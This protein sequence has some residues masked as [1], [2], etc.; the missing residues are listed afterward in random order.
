MNKTQKQRFQELHPNRK[1]VFVKP[2]NRKGVGSYSVYQ[3]NSLI[4]PTYQQIK[5]L[6][7]TEQQKWQVAMQDEISSLK[8]K[9][10]F[11]LIK[12]PIDVQILPTMWVFRIKFNPDG[13][14]DKYKARVVALGNLQLRHSYSPVIN[15]LSLRVLLAYAIKNKMHIHHVDI[16]T[17]YLNAPLKSK[18]YVQRPPSIIEQESPNSYCW[19]LTKSLYGLNESAANWYNHFRKILIERLQF[20]K[21]SVDNCIFVKRFG[22]D[23]TLIGVYVDDLVIISNKLNL[24]NDTKMSL[25]KLVTIADKG[26]IS[27]FLNLEIEYNREIGTLS[28]GQEQYIE[29][30]LSDF[31]M[32][33]CKIKKTPLPANVEFDLKSELSIDKSSIL[34]KKP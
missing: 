23:V 20:I 27:Q 8:E 2:V 25:N 17:A 10:V 4:V 22:S 19:L 24:V 21:S 18:V 26:Q 15:D 33:N 6:N 9:E 11:E 1:L 13:K 7:L 28:I 12:R 3:I 16:C 34:P 14:V 5:N 32:T 29:Q 31:D 30:L